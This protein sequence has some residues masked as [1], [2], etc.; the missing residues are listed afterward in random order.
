MHT[1]PCRE[2][3]R[4]VFSEI[5]NFEWAFRAQATKKKKKEIITKR[6]K[7][8]T[9]QKQKKKMKKDNK[10]MVKQTHVPINVWFT[11]RFRTHNSF[12]FNK[13]IFR[14]WILVCFSSSSPGSLAN[15]TNECVS[16]FFLTI[17]FQILTSVSSMIIYLPWVWRFFFKKKK[18]KIRRTLN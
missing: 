12:S 8:E 14:S 3:E 9:N 1:T 5:L 4:A 13:F 6:R 11:L 18:K 15:V 16:L 17:D 7:I 2:R 10:K